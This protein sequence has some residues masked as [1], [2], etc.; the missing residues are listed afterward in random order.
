MTRAGSQVLAGL[1]YASLMFDLRLPRTWLLLPAKAA[2]FSYTLYLVHWPLLVVL[3]KLMQPAVASHWPT[4]LVGTVVGA[5][6]ALLLAWAL[7]QPLEQAA[8]FRGLIHAAGRRLRWRGK[9]TP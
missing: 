6:S 5:A 9:R 1:A 8:R 3:A 7:A 4:A 2:V